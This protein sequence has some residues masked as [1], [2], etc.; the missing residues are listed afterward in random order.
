MINAISLPGL[1]VALTLPWVCGCIW[2]SWLLR[3]TG[4]CNGFIVLGQG[5][6][7]GTLITTL[8]IR[9]WNL[10]G[11]DLHFWGIAA[12]VSIFSVLGMVLNYR[13]PASAVTRVN[14]EPLPPWHIAVATLLIGLIAWRHLTM[15]QELLLRPLFA[16]DAWMNWAP[17]AIVWFH[18]GALVDFVRPEQWLHQGDMGTYTL[19]N[20]QASLYPI[21]VPLIQLWGMLGIGTWD[22]SAVYLPWIMAPICLGLAI[23]GH[24]RL[25][26]VSFL[27]AVIACY[28]LLSLPYLNVHSTLAGYADIWLAAAFGLAVCALYEWRLSRHWAY[29]VLWA[30]LALL[31][32]QLKNPGVVLAVII[33]VCGIRRWLNLSRKLEAV[34]VGIMAVFLVLAS[35]TGVDIH[36]PYVGQIILD[37]RT[38][39]IGKLGR[40]TLEYHNVGRP[41]LETFFVMVNWNLM[42]YLLPV[43]LLWY[44]TPGRF[45]RRPTSEFLPVVLALAFVVFVFVF[46][47]HYRAAENFVTLNRALLYPVPAII[48]CVFLCFRKAEPL[49]SRG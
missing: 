29:A 23:F 7:L 8:F 44:F 21:A 5:F 40:F 49:P 36:I 46:T 37:A 16:W 13:Y 48:F 34:L 39:E 38:I 43:F 42:W 19:G 45:V 15:L 31:C 32:V 18:H 35:A 27:R 20:R 33:V 10:I 12:V 14:R 9:L 24:L 26:G 41:L 4:R 47:K 22:H 17:K 25:A 1:F 28:L 30:L 2:I 3:R 11:F 6:F